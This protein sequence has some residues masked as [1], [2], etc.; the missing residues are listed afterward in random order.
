MSTGFSPTPD[1]SSRGE[2]TLV[3]VLGADPPHA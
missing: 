3:T 1:I 2:M